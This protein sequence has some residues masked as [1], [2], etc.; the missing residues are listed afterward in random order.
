[1]QQFRDIVASP[2]GRPISGATVT[3][4]FST[5]GTPTL[6]SDNGVTALGS[7][8]LTTDANGEYKFYAVNGRYT[9]TIAASGY[10]GT[11]RDVVLFD[12]ADTVAFL[13][14]Y[15]Y[16]EG[17]GVNNTA[18]LQACIDA[19]VAAR[20]TCILPA[21]PAGT[22]IEH[23]GLT[24]GGAV[25]I[26]GAGKF[27]TT[28]RLLGSATGA[29][30]ITITA[31]VDEPDVHIMDLGL[32][33][34]YAGSLLAGH[35]IYLPDETTLSYGRGV[36]LTRVYITQWYGKGLYIGENRNNG[37]TYDLEISRCEDGVYIDNSSDWKNFHGELGVMRQFCVNIPGAGA[38]NKFT[39]CSMWESQESAV[40]LGTTNSSP[41]TFTGC[42]FDHHEKNAVRISGLASAGQPH[43]FIGCWFRENSQAGD[44]LHAQILLTNTA[45]AVFVGNRFTDQEGNPRPSYVVEFSGTCDAVTWA[46]NYVE[47]DAYATAVTNDATKLASLTYTAR[48]LGTAAIGGESGSQSLNVGQGVAAGNYVSVQGV[49]AGN[50]PVITAAG[51]DTNAVLKVSSKGAS[52]VEI[53]T[54]GAN[55]RVARFMDVA[56]AVNRLDLYPGAT[57]GSVRLVAASSTDT[58]VD[59]SLEPQGTEGCVVVPTDSLRNYADD[60]AAATGGVPVRGLYHTSGAVKIRL[61]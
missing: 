34:R 16:V 55:T 49:A 36:R 46:E 6:Y 42:T 13:L 37:K 57:G 59:L 14:S 11:T 27:R 47:P 17:T 23:T 28:L 35:A 56:S 40:N 41:N 26:I 9:L 22:F 5:G 61:A 58:H 45:G 53:Y 52:A 44:G 48:I 25:T 19:G 4:T 32:D 7:N 10:S 31:G 39:D 30:G 21:V 18:A 50:G 54:N 12:P 3:V 24:I 8:V 51:A 1:M 43:A 15:G 2:T 20:G 29:H 60:A 33:G 38:D